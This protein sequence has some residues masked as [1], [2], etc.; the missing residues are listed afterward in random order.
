[1]AQRNVAFAASLLLTVVLICG[2]FELE[3]VDQRAKEAAA[4]RIHELQ[5]KL[6]DANSALVGTQAALIEAQKAIHN[7]ENELVNTR[8]ALKIVQDD[9]KRKVSERP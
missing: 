9:L 8:A 6:D 2:A 1:M 5:S 7:V 4:S 3:G